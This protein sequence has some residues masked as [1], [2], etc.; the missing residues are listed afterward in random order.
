MQF[1]FEDSLETLLISVFF[2]FRRLHTLIGHR[3]EISNAMFNFDCSLI[4][5][6]SMVR[7]FNLLSRLPL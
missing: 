4:V 6:A 3:G 7:S 1:D 5:S 2:S